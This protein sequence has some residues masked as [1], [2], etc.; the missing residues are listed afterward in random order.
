MN[1]FHLSCS[2]NSNSAADKGMSRRSDSFLSESTYC[3][4]T[5]GRICFRSVYSLGSQHSP[6][7]IAAIIPLVCQ[8]ITQKRQPLAGII[9]HLMLPVIFR[10]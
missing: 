9:M 3:P 5:R 4:D 6:D 8:Y 2:P 1:R 10:G 7:G